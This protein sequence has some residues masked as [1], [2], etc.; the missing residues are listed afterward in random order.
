MRQCHTLSSDVLVA[1]E[2]APFMDRSKIVLHQRRE[3]LVLCIFFLSLARA[4]EGMLEELCRVW[5]LGRILD[6]ASL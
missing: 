3:K 6:K 4:N 2:L 5:S 1:S